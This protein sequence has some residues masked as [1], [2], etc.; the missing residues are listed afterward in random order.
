MNQSLD[1]RDEKIIQVVLFFIVLSFVVGIFAQLAMHVKA[2]VYDPEGTEGYVEYTDSDYNWRLV[3][4]LN[5]PQ[6]KY[7]EI[8]FTID[9]NLKKDTDLIFYTLH[10]GVAV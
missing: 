7:S 8:T 6:N 9:P 5:A 1:K 10:S 3:D 4:D 2:F